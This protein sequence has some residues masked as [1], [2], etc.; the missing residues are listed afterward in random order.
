LAAAEQEDA[1]FAARC[2]EDRRHLA[3]VRAVRERAAAEYFARY[4]GEWDRLRALLSPAAKVESA[5]IKAFGKEPLGRVLD[6]GTGTGR[7]AALLAPR[8]DHVIAL[9]R[10]P[11]MLRLA[12]ARLQGLPAEQWEL[13][14]G[15]FNALPIPSASV[16][17]VVFHQVLHYAHEPDYALQEAARVCRPAGRIAIVDL[18]AHERE[19]LRKRHA[20]VRLGFADEQMLTLLSENGFAPSPPV[21]LPGKG[22]TTK[23][24]TG[25][26]VGGG[27]KRV[28]HHAAPRRRVSGSSRRT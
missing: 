26:R 24:W 14:Q 25:L 21:A 9:D 2:G 20:H 19:E 6:V 5:L 15:D 17:T 12:R 3:A 23:I 22:L 27:R 16:D 4:A 28:T 1:E 7:I 11:E 18:A 13:V 10:S 8:S